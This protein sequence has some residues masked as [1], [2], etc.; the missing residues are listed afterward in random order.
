MI[1]DTKDNIVPNGGLFG[2]DKDRN[3]W[4]TPKPLIGIYDWFGDPEADKPGNIVEI[5][6][7]KIDPETG[8]ETITRTT[9]SLP[10]D[11][12]LCVG[13]AGDI[14]QAGGYNGDSETGAISIAIASSVNDGATWNIVY[15]NDDL[16]SAACMMAAPAEMFS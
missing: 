5:I 1:K 9:K 6:K 11:H 3:I 10:M 12:V 14:W 7:K 8:A 13:R 4:I 2:W 16:R 15:A